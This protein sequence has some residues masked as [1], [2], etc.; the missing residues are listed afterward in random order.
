MYDN[1]CAEVAETNQKG[2]VLTENYTILPILRAHT[3][4]SF[5][6]YVR[7]SN[8]WNCEIVY[9]QMVR[10]CIFHYIMCRICSC[11]SREHSYIYA[12]SAEDNCT[13]SYYPRLE[14]LC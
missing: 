8:Y 4:A 5:S 14:N 10:N 7:T 1:V 3:I 11:L 13:D 9:G 12:A 6:R 2:K